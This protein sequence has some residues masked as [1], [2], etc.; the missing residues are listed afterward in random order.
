MSITRIVPLAAVLLGSALFAQQV[1]QPR[2][3]ASPTSEQ[4]ASW[5]LQLGHDS[6]QVRE[7]A[8][9]KLLQ[10][11][12]AAEPALITA[13][14]SADA[15]VARRARDLLERIEAARILRGHSKPVLS[16]VFS[17]GGKQ[18]A[19]ASSDQTVKLWD[20]RTGKETFSLKG[21]SRGLLSV[22][23][24]PD[25]KQIASAS[26]DETVKLWDA[27]T[28]K[29]T[30]SLKGHTRGALTAVFSPNGKQIATASSD[31]TVKVW[32]AH[33]GQEKL[34][35]KGHSCCVL[36][37]DFSPNGKRIVSASSDK[38]VKVWD[39]HTGQET[40][41]QGPH[42]HG[43]VRGVQPRWQTDRHRQ[44][45]QDG[46]ALGCADRSANPFSQR[47]LCRGQQRCVQP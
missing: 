4:I 36:S 34:S 38:T 31:K 10:A 20:A 19:S 45:G 6:F 43:L 13:A 27:Q 8:T 35:L 24:S 22:V 32:D 17:P 42:R 44:R 25:G 5:I 29:E 33:T 16:V 14:R 46:Q 15:E 39:A 3:A 41:S 1:K 18:I 9:A 7:Q 23:F 12:E 2:D 11:G 37:V 40:L 21:H 26:Y 47:P 30:F 28:G